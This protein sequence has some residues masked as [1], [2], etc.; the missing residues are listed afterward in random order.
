MR[1]SLTLVSVYLL[2]TATICIAAP[3]INEIPFVN[4]DKNFHRGIALGMYSQ[5]ANYDYRHEV[6]EIANTGATH[7]SLVV[8]YFLDTVTATKISAVAGYTPSTENIRRTLHY[9]F[10]KK[11]KVMLFPIVHIVHRGPGEWRGKLAPPDFGEW[12]ASYKK[13][14]TSMA[15]LAEECHSETLVVGTEY[16]T[17]ETMRDRWLD[18]ISTVRK[19]FHGKL[20][21]S[22]N[23]DHF[24]PVSFWDAVDM[25]G[26]TAYH[27]L[28]NNDFEPNVVEMTQAWEPIKRRLH[29]FQKR[30]NKPIVITE[31]GYPSLDGAN[32]YP[33]D[34]TRSVAIDLEEQ[35]R[36]YEAFA[37]A[38]THE[39]WLSGVYFW[40]WFGPGGSFDRGFT[41][42][43]KP[44][45]NVIRSFYKQKSSSL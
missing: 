23:W 28:T 1:T 22:A 24:D 38:F 9:A 45:E 29:N 7:I 43:G 32:V 6:D 35:R 42:H 8:V 10:N 31:L 19:V 20:L 27:R 40:I 13:F 17:T 18:V 34:E 39:T 44:A 12:F 14:I 5:D 11:L 33:W 4:A 37:R 16:V 36:C 30:V 15:K 25:V 41:P 3:Q 26:V 21:Y 2:C